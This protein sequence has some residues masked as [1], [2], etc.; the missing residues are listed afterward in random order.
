[1]TTIKLTVFDARVAVYNA[2]RSVDEY[3]DDPR[4]LPALQQAR[5]ALAEAMDETLLDEDPF[6]FPEV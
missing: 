4:V 2:L 5:E 6:T 1:M 3:P